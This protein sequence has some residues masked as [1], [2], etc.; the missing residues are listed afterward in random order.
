MKKKLVLPISIALIALLVAIIARMAVVN[1]FIA[2]GA[3]IWVLAV[4][5][6]LI[7]GTNE[8]FEKSIGFSVTPDIVSLFSGQLS[9]DWGYSY[10]LSFWIF[11]GIGSG[12]GTYFLLNQ[13]FITP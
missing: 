11:L 2:V 5:W 12:V 10:M 1:F 7:F 8:E 9:E 4:T 3:G 6:K 13:L